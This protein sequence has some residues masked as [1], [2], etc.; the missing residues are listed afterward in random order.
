MIKSI[1]SSNQFTV[2]LLGVLSALAA[3]FSPILLILIVITAVVILDWVTAVAKAIKDYSKKKETKV[4]FKGMSRLK[5]TWYKYKVVSSSKV[6]RTFFKLVFYLL[7]TMAI[8]ASEIA[9]FGQSIFAVNVCAGVLIFVELV[10]ISEN[11]DHFTG[12]T[13]FSKI[14]KK[15]RKYFEKKAED[16]IKTPDE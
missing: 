3:F 5:R 10:S 16:L 9:I 1:L 2:T 6:R 13:T 12:T 15:V 4:L 8:F 14:I 11:L 7:F